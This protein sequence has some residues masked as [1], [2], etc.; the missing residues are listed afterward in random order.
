MFHN[1][2]LG[3]AEEIVKKQTKNSRLVQPYVWECIISGFDSS[4][5]IIFTFI[6]KNINHVQSRDIQQQKRRLEKTFR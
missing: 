5:F 4:F 1:R 3:H 6:I 2:I